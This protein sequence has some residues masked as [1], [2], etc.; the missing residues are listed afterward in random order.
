MANQKEQVIAR[1][2]LKIA[3]AQRPVRR[4]SGGKVVIEQNGVVIELPLYG[5][6]TERK[7]SVSS[8]QNSCNSNVFC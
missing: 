5:G 1:E 4:I 8:R 2:L 7:T 3:K 6:S